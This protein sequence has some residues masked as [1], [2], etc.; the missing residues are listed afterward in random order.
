MSGL[1]YL[2]SLEEV[3]QTSDPELRDGIGFLAPDTVIGWVYDIFLYKRYY[4]Y[5]SDLFF[6]LV[7]MTFTDHL[8]TCHDM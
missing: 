7:M 5:F 4:P 1:S 3:S 8:I 6:D 2:S